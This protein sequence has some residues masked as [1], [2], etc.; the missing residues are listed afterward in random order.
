LRK[1]KERH[2]RILTIVFPHAQR[3]WSQSF[4]HWC[5]GINKSLGTMR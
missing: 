3:L 4:C 5:R 1:M 2:S